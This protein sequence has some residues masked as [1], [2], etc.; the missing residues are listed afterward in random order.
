MFPEAP[1]EKLEP[2][3][4]L[5][6]MVVLQY[7][8]KMETKLKSSIIDR[9]PSFCSASLSVIMVYLLDIILL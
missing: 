2:M 4:A 1:L 8:H 3:H 7:S 9:V 5:S 6:S